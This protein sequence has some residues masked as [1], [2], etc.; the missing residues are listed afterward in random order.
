MSEILVKVPE[1]VDE[2]VAKIAVERILQRLKIANE[3]F[4]ALKPKKK[5]EELAEGV[6]ETWIV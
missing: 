1:G 3:T 4:G 5:V 2:R 6:D